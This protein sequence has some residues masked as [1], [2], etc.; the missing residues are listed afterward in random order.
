VTEGNF[1]SP[2][3]L[4]FAILAS[5]VLQLEEAGI[6]IR[7]YLSDAPIRLADESG[8]IHTIFNS[9][10]PASS[11]AGPGSGPMTRTPAC[12]GRR[13]HGRSRLRVR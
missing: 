12:G 9:W 1:R 11:D 6:E 13:R 8:E 10:P 4:E 7:S 2:E 3:R 5:A